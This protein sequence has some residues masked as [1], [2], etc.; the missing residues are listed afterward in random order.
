MATPS[1]SSLNANNLTNQ[2]ESYYCETFLYKRVEV[3]LLKAETVNYVWRSNLHH[4]LNFFVSVH[5]SVCVY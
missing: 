4:S 3:I 5:Y 2:S 1:C